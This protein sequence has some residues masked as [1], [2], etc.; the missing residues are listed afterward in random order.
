MIN[1]ASTIAELE[2]L[3]NQSDFENQYAIFRTNVRNCMDELQSIFNHANNIEIN[4][5]NK[6]YQKLMKDL[7]PCQIAKKN[8]KVAGT[9]LILLLSP[10][11]LTVHS[12]WLT[13]KILEKTLN[14]VTSLM[15]RL[16]VLLNKSCGLPLP[17]RLKTTVVLNKS[18]KEMNFMIEKFDI[19]SSQSHAEQIASDMKV[20]ENIYDKLIK[21]QSLNPFEMKIDLTKEEHEALF[22][23]NINI[24]ERTFFRINHI[25]RMI[26]TTLR[27]YEQIITTHNNK[28]LLD[29]QYKQ[30][31]KK[32]KKL[33]KKSYRKARKI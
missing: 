6:L 8:D 28:T 27:K 31:V 18:I 24:N 17:E 1:L 13:L 30:E 7:Y 14:T 19:I 15:K 3:K 21:T 12:I 4:C 29:Q 10:Y 2:Q 26:S 11:Y 16:L 9:L 20:L 23:S 25:K 33:L 32:C 5:S 22:R